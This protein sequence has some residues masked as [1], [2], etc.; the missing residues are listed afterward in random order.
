MVA[1]PS[2]PRDIAVNSLRWL[3]CEVA[4]EG[5]VLHPCGALWWQAASVLVFSDLHLEKASSYAERGQ[6]LPPY[7]TG[8]TLRRAARLVD[9]LQPTTVI[10]LGDSF[11]DRRARSRMTQDDVLVVRSLTHRADWVWIEGNHDPQPPED[12]GG[13]VARELRLGPLTFRHEPQ[14]GKVRGEIAGHLHPCARVLGRGRSVRARC[15]A[16]DGERMVMPAYGAL[17]GGLNVLDAAF[18]ALFPNGMI[19]AVLGRDGVYAAAG[20]RLAADALSAAD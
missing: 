12:L 3:A 6:M 16:S 11:H 10:A 8:A 18:S 2:G 1:P 20:E 15:F 17:T 7:D 4:G 14:A 5:L 9:A 19:A 13:R